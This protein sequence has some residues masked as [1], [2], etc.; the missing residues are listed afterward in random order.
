WFGAALAPYVTVAAIAGWLSYGPY[1]S[2]PLPI[3]DARGAAREE[4]ELGRALRERGVKVAGAQF[5]LG[6]RLTFLF[7][8]NPV[9]A[10]LDGENR[11]PPYRLAFE[12]S[13]D[14]AFIFHPSERRLR[15][16]PFEEAFRRSGAQYEPLD[17]AGF[18]VLLYH[19][20]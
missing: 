7:D 11:Y 8:E 19:R 3:L 2:G 20:R 18:R 10:P 6:Y 1:V 14:V 4:R 5:W 16:E 17:V 13:K 12:R 9:V 15:P